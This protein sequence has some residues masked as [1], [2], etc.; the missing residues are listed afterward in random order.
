MTVD[1]HK[2]HTHVHTPPHTH[3]F[4]P[5]FSPSLPPSLTHSFSV[6]LTHQHYAGATAV[7]PL[8]IAKTQLQMDKTGKDSQKLLALLL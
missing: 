2:T 3:S 6:S 7:Y 1:L 8:D 4:S 5:S